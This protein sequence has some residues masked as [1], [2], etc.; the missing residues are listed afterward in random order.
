MAL[1]SASRSSGGVLLTFV[2][3]LMIGFATLA[4]AP[5][6][7]LLIASASDLGL[8]G[9]LIGSAIV[10]ALGGRLAFIR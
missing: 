10:A 7:L 2:G 6:I 1:R 3:W 4:A 5:I 9:A 8:W